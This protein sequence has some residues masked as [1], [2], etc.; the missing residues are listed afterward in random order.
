[1]CFVV[2]KTT[3]E[4]EC[5]IL[6]TL[7]LAGAKNTDSWRTRKGDLLCSF[8]LDISI[9]PSSA[10]TIATDGERLSCNVFSLDEIIRFRS[11]KFITDRF[12][13]LCL[14]PMGDGL[15]ATVMGSTHGGTPSP[16]WAMTEDSIKEFHTTSN[17]E[18]RINLP[19]P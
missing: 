2:H 1:V 5:T 13:D 6:T 12:G 17:G 11:I 9:V 4:Q 7:Y 3:L 15:G 10:L 18:G 14:S 19:S 16:L 8:P